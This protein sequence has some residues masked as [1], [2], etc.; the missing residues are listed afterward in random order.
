MDQERDDDG[1]QPNPE[2][3]FFDEDLDPLHSTSHLDAAIYND[4]IEAV[5]VEGRVFTDH[6]QVL[7]VFTEG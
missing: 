4:Q 1:D 7:P 6:L 2:D 3:M 5:A